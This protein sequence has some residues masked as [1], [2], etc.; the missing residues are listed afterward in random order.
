M[1][2]LL[3]LLLVR[4]REPL[5]LLLLRLLLDCAEAGRQLQ[6]VH[7]LMVEAVMMIA[8]TWNQMAHLP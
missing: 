4:K 3:Q 6:L 5:L 2:E 1:R 7:P 8:V